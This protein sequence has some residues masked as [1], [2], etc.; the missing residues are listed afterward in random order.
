MVTFYEAKMKTKTRFLIVFLMA[1]FPVLSQAADCAAIKAQ[2]WQCVRSSM[3]GQS[4][5]DNVTIPPECLTASGASG[6]KSEK[7]SDSS[8]TYSSP[9]NSGFF[10]SKKEQ[11]FS[12]PKNTTPKKSVKTI[13]LKAFNTKNYLETE[14]DV[15]LFTSKLKEEMSNAIKDGKRIRL[16][17]R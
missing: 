6:S 15:E 3:T 4:C 16:Q 10:N 12:Y 13:N 1:L 17:Y 8:S 11:A 7:T 14:E 9:T 2:Y 5:S